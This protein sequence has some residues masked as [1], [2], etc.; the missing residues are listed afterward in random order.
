MQECTGEGLVWRTEGDSCHEAVRDAVVLCLVL[1]GAQ[2][3]VVL[4]VARLVDL[5]KHRGRALQEQRHVR[6]DDDEDAKGA[7]VTVL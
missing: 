2:L 6:P 7:C 1:L 4:L 5:G 3:D